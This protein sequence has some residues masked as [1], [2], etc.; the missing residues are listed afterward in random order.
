[1]TPPAARRIGIVTGLISEA[2]CLAPAIRALPAADRPTVFC[3]GGDARRAAD[4]VGRLIGDGIS[5]LL[6][7][8]F[9][10][11]L[12]PALVPGDLVV[13]G[14]VIAPD[15]TRFETHDGWREALA[16]AA[17]AS[18]PVTLG[19]LAGCDTAITTAAAKSNLQG[20]TGAAAVDLESHAV[21]AAAR[22]AGL[23]F[24]AVR[25]IADPAD[26]PIPAAALAGLS[27]DGH[28]RPFAVLAKLALRPWDLPR[29]ARLAED[30]RAA[31]R[32][33]RRV[34]ALGAVVVQ[35]RVLFDE[36]VDLP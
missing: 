35:P 19:T 26:R 32:A 2:K 17:A 23:P 1:M 15:G 3:S 29:M 28:M 9:A 34:A 14:A 30:T 16:E 10:G 22:M 27:P 12:D 18:V 25:A 13:A 8:G 21:A 4:G 24:L 36:L 31:H 5:G 33:L 20:S 7:F 6:S 11:G